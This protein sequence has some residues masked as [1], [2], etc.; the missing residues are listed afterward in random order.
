MP[1]LGTVARPSWSFAMTIPNSAEADVLLTELQAAQLLQISIRTLQ[2]W[3]LRRSGPAY[4]Q[5]GRAVRYRKSDL[6]GWID[7]NTVR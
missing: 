1:N 4:V 5:L 6:M 2:A 3:R 7:S